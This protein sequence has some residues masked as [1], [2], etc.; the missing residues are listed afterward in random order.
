MRLTRSRILGF[1]ILLLTV[2]PMLTACGGAATSTV[3][4]GIKV[5]LAAD[6]GGLN[7]KS[8][9]Q[10]ANEGLLKAETDFHVQGS[11]K[12]AKTGDDYV[13]NLTDFATQSCGLIVAVG[14]LIQPAV[15]QVSQ[16]FPNIHF[17]VVDGGA[18]DANFNPV[19][20]A[21]VQSLLFKEEEAGALVGVI[22]G[23]LEKDGLTPNKTHRVSTVGG[24]K[25]PPVDHYIAGFQWG[26]KQEDPNLKTPLNAYSNDFSDSAKCRDIANQQISAGSEIIFQVAGGC[27]NGALQAAGQNHVYSIG[28]DN[29]QKDVDPSVIASALKRVDVA[30]Y[31]AIKAANSGQFQAGETR[32]SLANDGVGYAP[33]NISLPAD[34]TAEVTRVASQIKS[35]A[36]T[37]PNTVP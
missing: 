9:N 25:I 26:A 13:P 7:D 16:Q 17:A 27:G 36:V 15:G 23:V 34:V 21:N 6:T 2:V 14:F 11:V 18:T 31:N 28:V 12:V 5:C 35:G 22:A 20:R 10:L 29:D 1:G 37:V 3:P 8:F 4:P 24:Q 32:F 30:V 19:T 33:G